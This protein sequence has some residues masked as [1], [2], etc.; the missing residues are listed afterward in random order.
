MKD[1]KIL[2]C[3]AHYRFT[4]KSGSEFYSVFALVD[5]LANKYPKSVVVVGKSDVINA[6]YRI[7]ETHPKKNENWMFDLSTW[8][9][10]DSIIFALKYVWVGFWELQ[11]SSFDIIHHVRP[12]SV[13]R[14]FNLLPLIPF[15]KKKPFVI[16]EFCSPYNS[17]N[18]EGERIFTFRERAVNYF[19]FL[20]EPILKKLSHMT[21]KRA[22]A[23][24]VT[25][26]NARKIVEEITDIDKIYIVPDGKN[27]NEYFLDENKFKNIKI[28]IFSAGRLIPRKRMDLA[29]LAFSQA[30][31]KNGDI[32]LQIAGDGP[33]KN[34]LVKLVSRLGIERN[35]KF[36]GQVPYSEMSKIFSQ[37]HIFLHTAEE[38]AFGQVYIESLASG[39][40][41]ITT[42]TIGSG[43][44]MTKYTGFVT[45]STVEDLSEAMVNLSS[46]KEKLV[47][48]SR[49]SRSY[50]LENYDLND[51]IIPKIISV[52]KSLLLKKR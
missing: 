1:L 8:S 24:F 34:R 38:E 11:S 27:K 16:G 29:I 30:L 40:P 25:D 44:I 42:R 14:T 41:V 33:E 9:T 19:V 21:L 46:N 17:K 6:A 3:P 37:A 22:D 4:G 51:I 10:I 32:E 13:G 49:S 5:T 50:F 31:R 35:V 43:Q 39:V 48:M 28:I 52:Y 26:D 23:I 18:V 47:E 15:L 20:I 12:F 36:L 45:D 7:I 2:F